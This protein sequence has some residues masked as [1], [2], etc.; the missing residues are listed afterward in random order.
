MSMNLNTYLIYGKNIY[1]I[2]NFNQLLNNFLLQKIFF[3]FR[4]H[5]TFESAFKVLEELT[6]DDVT[7]KDWQ[8]RYSVVMYMLKKSSKVSL[9]FQPYNFEER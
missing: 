9:S 5:Q 2:N 6:V 3:F 7:L 8:Q 1:L 4:N